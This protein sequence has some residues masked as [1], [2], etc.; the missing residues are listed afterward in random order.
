MYYGFIIFCVVLFVYIHFQFHLKKSCEYEIYDMTDSIT[1][2]KLDELC[3]IRQPVLF[4]NTNHSLM[5]INYKTMFEQYPSYTVCLRNSHETNFNS[6]IYLQVSLTSA[7]KLIAEKDKDANFYYSEK[8]EVFT[9]DLMRLT[10]IE[11]QMLKIELEEKLLDEVQTNINKNKS[12]CL[13]FKL[14]K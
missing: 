4:L 13:I 14:F 7:L 11:D 3:D 6:E 1:K 5:D 9:A 12:F 2:E 10:N 8:N